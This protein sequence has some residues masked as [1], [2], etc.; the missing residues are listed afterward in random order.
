MDG[1][2]K[3]R[4]C[5]A[6]EAVVREGGEEEGGKKQERITLDW[7]EDGQGRWGT[8]HKT[9]HEGK[10]LL[11]SDAALVIAR[12]TEARLASEDLARASGATDVPRVGDGGA[13]L[14]GIKVRAAT[15]AEVGVLHG[16]NASP[17]V[18]L[19]DSISDVANGLSRGARNSL[20]APVPR[21]DLGIR[22][23]ALAV[24]IN[25]TGRSGRGRLRGVRA[26]L[27]AMVPGALVASGSGRVRG[28]GGD[29]ALVASVPL[30]LARAGLVGRRARGL[31]LA[32]VVEAALSGLTTRV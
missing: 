4:S 22:V 27:L 24:V 14:A 28:C 8:R 12:D 29:T 17:G 1:G 2:V 23:R 16:V 6:C 13:V 11:E 9:R 19:G 30:E 15:T 5:T 26:A 7:A 32:T 21:S 20:R 10:V 3:V 18:A 25:T 31:A